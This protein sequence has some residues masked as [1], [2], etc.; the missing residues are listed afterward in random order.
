MKKVEAPVHTD[1]TP[2]LHKPSPEIL[3]VAALVRLQLDEEPLIE[4]A[5]SR[6]DSFSQSQGRLGWKTQD[7]LVL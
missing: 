6:L 4:V 5:G 7:K 3:G 1:P 2:N